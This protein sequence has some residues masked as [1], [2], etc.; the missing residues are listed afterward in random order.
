VQYGEL[1]GEI[2]PY[3]RDFTVKLVRNFRPEIGLVS[4]ESDEGRRTVYLHNILTIGRKRLPPLEP[5]R[6]VQNRQALEA[7]ILAKPEPAAEVPAPAPA[8]RRIVRLKRK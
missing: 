3:E 5:P 7:A 4:F 6:I 2:I 8:P 1:G